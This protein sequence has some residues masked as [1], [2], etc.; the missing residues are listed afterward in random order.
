MK[1]QTAVCFPLTILF[2][3]LFNNAFATPLYL[4]FETTGTIGSRGINANDYIGNRYVVM[5]ETDEAAARAS[6]IDS[7][8]VTHYPEDLDTPD[9]KYDHFYAEGIYGNYVT[10]AGSSDQDYYQKVNLGNWGAYSEYKQN[11]WGSG[12]TYGTFSYK[13]RTSFFYGSESDYVSINGLWSEH[14]WPPSYPD[15]FLTSSALWSIYDYSRDINN[16]EVFGSF[17]AN[18]V[19][20]SETNPVPEPATV[21]LFGIGVAGLVSTRYR[22]KK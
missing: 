20:V 4:T 11:V 5:I 3:L 14:I 2:L 8:G 16:T 15:S 17:W 10:T 22:K 19:D 18:L 13:T 1:F 21:F 7:S 9:T 12:A 6:Y